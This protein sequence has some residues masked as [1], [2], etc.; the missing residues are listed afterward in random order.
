MTTTKEESERIRI[1]DEISS[2][3]ATIETYKNNINVEISKMHKNE[4]E[5]S[6]ISSKITNLEETVKKLE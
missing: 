4:I 6:T 2:I 3:E 1:Q 5:E